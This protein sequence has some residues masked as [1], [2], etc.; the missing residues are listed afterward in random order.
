MEITQPK[1]ADVLDGNITQ[2]QLNQWKY[3]HKKV[4]KLTITDDDGTILFAYF[5]VPDI[6][7]R[8][9]VLQASKMD[10]FK[11]LEVLFKNCYLGGDGKIEQEDDL[12]LNITTAFSDHI[13]PK[14]V[15][16]EVL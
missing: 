5:K 15:K 1:T 16:V 13:Q 4:I 11:A 3:K 12:R 10:E 9:A 7:I 2:A 8:S 14:P 6:S